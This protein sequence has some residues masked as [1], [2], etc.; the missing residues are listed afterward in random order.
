VPRLSV[1]GSGGALVRLT[2]GHLTDGPWCPDPFHPARFD[3]DLLRIRRVVVRVRVQAAIE[4]LRG[5]AGSLFRR[6]GTARTAARVVPDLE[7]T[8]QV[9]PGNLVAFD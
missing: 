8:V 5:P 1:L 3:A 9:A 2:E 7:A 6:G 4:S